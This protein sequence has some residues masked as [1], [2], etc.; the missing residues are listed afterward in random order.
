MIDNVLER[1]T[2]L[3]EADPRSGQALLLYGLCKTLDIEKGGHMY[4]LRKLI[5]MTSE[6]RQL[7]YALMESM[8]L[9]ENG[10]ESWNAALAR[11][12]RVI[13]A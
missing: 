8:S 5:D 2:R 3:I 7:S 9:G 6:N 4:M 11:M 10:G 1:V 13:R 12:D